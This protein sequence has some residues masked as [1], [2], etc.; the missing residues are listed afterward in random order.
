LNTSGLGGTI[1]TLLMV[2]F[3]YL[4]NIIQI[5]VIGLM[6]NKSKRDCL[7]LITLNKYLTNK[8][9][10]FSKYIIKYYYLYQAFQ[11]KILEFEYE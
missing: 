4:T 5:T 9:S 11:E 1:N 3:R 7:S 2:V 10:N 6:L 8:K